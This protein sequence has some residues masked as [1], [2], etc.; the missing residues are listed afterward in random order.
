MAL[1]P[2]TDLHRDYNGE[3]RRPAGWQPPDQEQVH[4]RPPAPGQSIPHGRF[5]AYDKTEQDKF[6]PSLFPPPAG[7]RRV[8]KSRKS[9]RK[10]RRNRRR[11]KRKTRSR[12]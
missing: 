6:D 11:V 8:R 7:R 9:R 4:Y 2:G 1:Y 10:S 12:R 3:L 5:N